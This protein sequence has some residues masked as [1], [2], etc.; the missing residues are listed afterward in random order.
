MEKLKK[1]MDDV[2]GVFAVAIAVA[3]VIVVFLFFYNQLTSFP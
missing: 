3:I 1:I 2:K